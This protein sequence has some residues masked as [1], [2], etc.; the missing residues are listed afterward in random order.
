MFPKIAILVVI[1]AVGVWWI[2][3]NASPKASSVVVLALNYLARPHTYLQPGYVHKEI[4]S[5]SAWNGTFMSQN[6]H[7]WM[8]IL[9]NADKEAMLQ[10]V[11]NFE[12][13][14]KTVESMSVG[15]FPLSSDLLRKIDSWKHQLSGTGRG[16]QLVRGVPVQQWTIKQSEIF[17]FALGKY[18]GVPGAQD[19]QGS[20]LGHVTDV[21]STNQTERPYRTHADIGYHCDGADI[22]GLL[23]IHPA[24]SGGAS[25]IISSV[26]MY[27]QLLKH[28]QGQSYASRIYN[29]I[30]LFTRKTFG[31]SAYLPVF[32]L[33]LDGEGVL[34]TY[35]NQ[36]FYTK[37]Y[38]HP[39][40][41]LTAAG[42][43]DPLALEAVEAYDVVLNEDLRVAKLKFECEKAA[44]SAA[45]TGDETG[46]SSAEEE[47]HGHGKDSRNK[48]K[49][50]EEALA[51]CLSQIPAQQFG[52]DM[53]LQQGDVQLVSNHFIMHSRTEFEDY[54]DAE[55][56]AA[57]AAEGGGGGSG[58]RGEGEEE[59][60]ERIGPIGKRD[61]LRLWVSHP[62]RD[63][64]WEFFLHKQVDL[65]RVLLN[66]VEGV[67]RYRN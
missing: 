63:M 48:K 62:T 44:A 29:R 33:R 13:L 24:K 60:E 56:A 39:N 66:L 52:L 14:N 34:R 1:F 40:G 18:L 42:E 49:K 36:E 19:V 7:I 53:F 46:E 31:L 30:L 10:A 50:N 35:W 64:T 26:T 22:V 65:V 59:E 28:K 20:L 25:R 21:G 6:P 5:D 23:C 61:L 47:E 15:D 43:S 57:K 67:V 16:F 17:F 3:K 9:T 54:S 11:R 58:G 51:A 37:S 32:P 4:I 38:R 27:N 12:A 41:T 2:S 55:I 45:G 8:D